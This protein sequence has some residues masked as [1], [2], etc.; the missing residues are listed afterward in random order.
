MFVPVWT[1]RQVRTADC[2]IIVTARRRLSR[3][4]FLL[5]S[6]CMSDLA[7]QNTEQAHRPIGTVGYKRINQ[8]EASGEQAHR[9]IRSVPKGQH[10]RTNH[11]RVSQSREGAAQPIRFVWQGA[12]TDALSHQKES[13]DQPTR[14]I[15]RSNSD[16]LS[17]DVMFFGLTSFL[18]TLHQVGIVGSA[19]Q[20]PRSEYLGRTNSDGLSSD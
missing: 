9:P 14:S 8:S 6:I 16:G 13:S 2:Y 4:R 10:K 19:N 11:Q 20:I 7:W 12:L 1:S 5:S 3:N 15:D 18:R 17:S